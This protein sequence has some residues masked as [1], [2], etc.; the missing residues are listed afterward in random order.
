MQH[1]FLFV[2]KDAL[3]SDIAWQIIKEGHEAKYFIENK[4]EDDIADGFVP[5][6]KDWRECLDWADVIVFDDVLGQGKIAE[7]LRGKGKKVIGGTAYTDMLED[8]RSFGQRELK[9]HGVKIIPFWEFTNFDEAIT[10]VKEHPDEYVIKPSG[11]AQNIKRLL[12]V[13]QE[14]DGNDVV[15]VLESYKKV[16]S[17]EVKIFQLQKMVI[18]VEV[19]VGAFF[20]GKDFI[21][22]ININFEHKKLFPGNFGPATGEMG[23]SM[24][25]SQPNILFS[26]TLEKLKDTLCHENYVGY[27]DLNCIVNGHGIYPLEFTSRFGYPT[28][29]IQQEGMITPIGEFFYDLANGNNIDLKCKTGF[30]VGVRLVVPPYPFKD[31]MT[32]DSF[33]KGAIIAFKGVQSDNGIHIEDVKLV[34][35]QWIITGSSGVALIVVGTGLTMKEAQKQAYSRIKNILIPNMYY[36]YDIG[37]RWYEEFDK[38]HSW[39]YIR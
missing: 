5:K 37:D 31:K 33:S 13:G 20:N 6:T 3:I 24:F 34:N 35:D 25:W 30:Q 4:E 21:Y 1:K 18:G 36:R 27:I 39:G 8:D 10:F 17:K 28:I 15:R 9:R 26:S 7:E 19:A 14:K 22:P 38:L 11:E 29:S 16:W 12:F 32:F 23:T 2:S